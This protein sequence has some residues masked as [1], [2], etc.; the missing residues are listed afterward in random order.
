VRTSGSLID[1]IINTEELHSI[2]TNWQIAD[3]TVTADPGKLKEAFEVTQ[4]EISNFWREVDEAKKSDM[5]VGDQ[6]CKI[7]DLL[8][9]RIQP[10]PLDSFETDGTF[11]NEGDGGV[12]HDIMY[13]T[14]DKSLA[15]TFIND[16]QDKIWSPYMERVQSIDDFWPLRDLCFLVGYNFWESRQKTNEANA[17]IEQFLDEADPASLQGF[18]MQEEHYSLAEEMPELYSAIVDR[19]VDSVDVASLGV[20]FEEQGRFSG[21]TKE[22]FDRLLAKV[23]SAD[24]ETKESLMQLL[25]EFHSCYLS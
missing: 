10:L 2:T 25:E 11:V 18:L 22:Q 6:L 24:P 17:K 3:Q 7:T 8:N 9:E 23:E 14:T 19:F 15:H 21:M 16:F 13:N 12:A 4:T 20:Y 5:S 1:T